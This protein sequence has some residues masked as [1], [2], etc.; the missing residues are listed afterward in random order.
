MTKSHIGRKKKSNIN[1]DDNEEKDVL[2]RA[3]ETL[4]QIYKDE[5][6]EPGKLKLLGIKQQWTILTGTNNE[7]GMVLNFS[8]IH[9][10]SKSDQNE[11][12]LP[13]EEIHKKVGKPIFDFFE[14]FI[15]SPGLMER[16]LCLT[17]L[18]ALSYRLLSTERLYE[19]EILY[20]TDDYNAYIRP[21]DIVTVIG[22][23]GMVSHFPGICKEV[24][25]TDLRPREIFETLIIGENIEKGPKDIIFHS[26]EENQAV[27]SKSDVV[28]ITGSTLVNGTF[29]ELISYAG[30]CRIKAVYGSSAQLVPEFFFNN[31]INLFSAMRIKDYE[32]LE[33]DIINHF[34]M[35]MAI[36]NNQERYCFY[37]SH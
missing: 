37:K 7:V 16:S 9:S 23:G 18:N 15:D 12:Q 8:G 29:D 4:R 6:I 32:K 14:M 27:I 30:N 24:H 20:T 26:A 13:I 31:G 33:H 22:W 17:A 34:N 2:I 3:C 19:K 21:D 11:Y 25:V 36:Q 28:F 5:S 1:N 10:G 35:E